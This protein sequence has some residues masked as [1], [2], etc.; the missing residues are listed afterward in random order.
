M[1][2]YLLLNLPTASLEEAIR[3]LPAMRSPTV[4]PLAQPDWCSL[5]TVVDQNRL[6][7]VIEKLKAI[8]AEGILVLNLEKIVL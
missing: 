3:I 6:W 2:K 5:Q 4:I 1:K 8:G 7:D